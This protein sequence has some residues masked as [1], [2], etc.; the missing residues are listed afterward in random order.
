MIKNGYA[1]QGG[2]EGCAMVEAGQ[3]PASHR[4]RPGSIPR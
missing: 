1:K 3:S 4:G 2:R